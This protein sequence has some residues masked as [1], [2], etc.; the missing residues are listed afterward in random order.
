[1]WTFAKLLTII[2]QY[3]FVM[4]CLNCKWLTWNCFCQQLMHPIADFDCKK[5][6]RSFANVLV[7]G[8]LR[9]GLGN[10][11]S[12]FL[13]SLYQLEIKR[14]LGHGGQG[15]LSLWRYLQVKTDM[16]VQSFFKKLIYDTGK[17]G[18]KK[19]SGCP[20]FGFLG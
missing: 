14:A 3:K 13:L 7:D 9:I 19:C 2:L 15:F 4:G 17:F 8:W 16:S 6:I 11:P 1:M 5:I 18:D 20:C 12:V 10:V